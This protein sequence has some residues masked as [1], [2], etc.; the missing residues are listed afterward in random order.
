MWK[1]KNM[2]NYRLTTNRLP[3]YQ[4]LST[5]SVHGSNVTSVEI[6]SVFCFFVYFQQFFRLYVVYKQGCVEH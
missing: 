5:F 1:N 6:I 2:D 4:Q 3:S